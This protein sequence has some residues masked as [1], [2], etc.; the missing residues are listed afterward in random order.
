EPQV[1][2]VPPSDLEPFIGPERVARLLGFA[3]RARE[4]L[5][6]RVFWH[7]NSTASGGGVAEMLAVDLAYA[8]G[9]GI[10]TRWLVFEG[11]PQFF[12]ITKRLHNKLHGAPGDDG[13]LGEV[14][15]AAFDA[16]TERNVEEF[17]R[18]LSPGDVVTIHDPQPAGLVPVLTERGIPV[19]WRCHVGRDGQ[20]GYS[21]EAWEFLRPYIT[22]ADLL[23]FSR[24]SYVPDFV[25]NSRLVIIPPAIDPFSPK[26]RPLDPEVAASILGRA[27]I[28]ARSD[29]AVAPA[30]ERADGSLGIVERVAEVV[31]EGPPP[32]ADAPLVLQVSRWDR[33][34]DMPGVLRGFVEHV[35]GSPE[36][37]GA[38]LVLAG[39]SVAGVTDD[40]E[41]Q[42][43]LAECTYLWQLLPAEVR[44]RVTLASLP[45]EDARE[46]AAIVNALQRHAA[47]VLQ[48]SLVEGFGLTA[49]EAMWKARPVVVSA[50]GGLLDQVING[51]SGILLHD[52][53]DLAAL[54]AALRTLLG[55]PEYAR[56]LGKA[57][58]ER[59]R[60][61]FL[62][63]R[64]LAQWAEVLLRLPG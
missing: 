18:R 52:P 17:L 51:E 15:R 11:D 53:T 62:P 43:V 21:R 64:Q 25:D 55:S 50:V 10:D 49:A 16:T 41:G 45:M 2:P 7:A 30:Y 60:A 19:V 8:Q 47:V 5:R 59:V 3:G 35:A 61:H 27:G 46:N 1:I 26:N 20:N 42:E 23:V 39:P 4:R 58:Q 29:D 44:S 36:G 40:P 34:K 37:K 22:R 9:M 54:G 32:P 28:A 13:P 57:A 56:V 24:A 63:D 38:H 31:R 48:K 12:V 33:L 6:G 14:E